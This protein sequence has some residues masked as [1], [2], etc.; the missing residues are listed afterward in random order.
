MV[1]EL[2]RDGGDASS[3]DVLLVAVPSGEIAGGLDKGR[4][5]EEMLAL[6]FAVNQAGLGVHFHRFAPP[7]EL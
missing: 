1:Q 5:L 3:A 6:L 4:L 2:G 7:G